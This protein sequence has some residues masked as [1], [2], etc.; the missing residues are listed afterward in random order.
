L[1]ARSAPAGRAAR[2]QRVN[3]VHSA[4]KNAGPPVRG[5]GFFFGL[6]WRVLEAATIGNRVRQICREQIWTPSVRPQGELQG[7]SESVPSTPP[8][9]KKGTSSGAF[10]SFN[11][12]VVTT[13][14]RLL[15]VTKDQSAP[16]GSIIPVI[17]GGL[18]QRRNVAGLSRPLGSRKIHARW[19]QGAWP[20]ALR[21]VSS[22]ARFS[23][24]AEQLTKQ[25][26][27][28]LVN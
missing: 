24:L 10:L 9:M 27:A 20:P 4:T 1:D 3:P 16:T 19:R 11:R 13:A 26:L 14:Y 28:P 17:S 15:C 22:H 7:C 6:E 2:M 25:S 5:L 12:A 21:R 23:L 8:Q 18:G